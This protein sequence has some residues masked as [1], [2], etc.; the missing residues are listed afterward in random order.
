MHVTISDILPAGKYQHHNA[1]SEVLIVIPFSSQLIIPSTHVRVRHCVER[2]HLTATCR[3]CWLSVAMRTTIVQSENLVR[4]R[5]VIVSDNIFSC[6]L[7]R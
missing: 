4:Q 6:R 3:L 1:V 2:T 5:D 7:I